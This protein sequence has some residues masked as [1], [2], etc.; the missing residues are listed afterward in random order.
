MMKWLAMRCHCC[1]TTDSLSVVEG[2]RKQL[3]WRIMYDA[4]IFY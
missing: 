2:G 1:G 3:G 4:D